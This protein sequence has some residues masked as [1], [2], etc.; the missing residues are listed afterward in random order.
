[1]SKF[2]EFYNAHGASATVTLSNSSYTTFDEINHLTYYVEPTTSSDGVQFDIIADGSPCGEQVDAGTSITALSAFAYW[3][4]ATA[5]EF[6]AIITK[7]KIEFDANLLIWEHPDVTMI[8]NILPQL[9][10]ETGIEIVGTEF[11]YNGQPFDMWGI[12]TSSAV[13]EAGNTTKLIAALPDYKLHGINTVTVFYQGSSGGSHDPFTS[14]GT[15]FRN[16]EFATRMDQIIAAAKDLDMVVIVGMFYQNIGVWHPATHTGSRSLANW[17]A[18]KEAMRTVTRRHI[19]DTNVIINVSNEQNSPG[20]SDDP[21]SRVRNPVDIIELCRIV[22][23]EDPNRLAGSGGYDQN[24]NRQIISLSSSDPL[25]KADLLLFDTLGGQNSG[26]IYDTFLS[27]GLATKPMVNVEYFGSWTGNYGDGTRDPQGVTPNFAKQEYF[28]EV[29]AISTRPGLSGFF[30]NDGWCQ[31]P[32][33]G[34]TL[35]YDLA[36]CGTGTSDR[37]IRWYFEYVHDTLGL[38]N[39]TTT[40]P[41]F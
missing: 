35:R 32:M 8:I 25:A 1:M 17:E 12:R 10:V 38:S 19:G 2:A 27:E 9:S 5:N 33:F 7:N 20:F 4:G 31:A 24:R 37:G 23:E 21:W 26:S 16:P 40:C 18:S 39:I 13:I 30:H 28:D 41:V 6:G 15:G 34:W 14:D 22:H 11:L 3:Y 29:D 36:G